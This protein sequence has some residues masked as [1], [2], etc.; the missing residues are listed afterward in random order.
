MCFYFS[1]YLY[2]SLQI[3]QFFIL[4]I[5]ISTR[6]EHCEMATKMLFYVLSTKIVQRCIFDIEALAQGK[7]KETTL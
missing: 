4:T 6:L 7:L 2:N 3:L 5:F 1:T